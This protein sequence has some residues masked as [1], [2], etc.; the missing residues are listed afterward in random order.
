MKV[1]SLTISQVDNTGKIEFQEFKVFWEK[2]KKWLVS[3][4][5][6]IHYSCTEKYLESKTMTET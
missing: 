6:M 3:V 2:L 4:D 5:L 1:S